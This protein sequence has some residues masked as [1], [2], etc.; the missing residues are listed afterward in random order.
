[1]NFTALYL[2]AQAYYYSKQYEKAKKDINTLSSVDGY[3]QLIATLKIRC[4]NCINSFKMKFDSIAYTGPRFTFPLTP[5]NCPPEYLTDGLPRLFLSRQLLPYCDLIELIDNTKTVLL[6]EA[7]IVGVPLTPSGVTV[8]GDLHGQ[9]TDLLRIFSMVGYPSEANIFI[10]NGDFI[11][12]G[13]FSLEVILTLFLF[14]CRYVFFLLFKLSYFYYISLNAYNHRIHFLN[15]LSHSTLLL[16][17][18]ILSHHF[19][20]IIYAFIFS[21]LRVLFHR[22][23]FLF[24]SLSVILS[25]SFSYEA[26]TRQT[27]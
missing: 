13:M 15:T 27:W 16:L 25:M 19:S 14:K 2:R 7:N 9:Y 8:V 5:T 6:N 10:F 26:T 21:I 4:A 3:M 11:D 20:H 24:L 22:S 1:M 18:H 23:F 17:K 12:R